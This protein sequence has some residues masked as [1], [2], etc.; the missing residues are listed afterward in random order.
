MDA[1]PCVLAAESSGAAAA[2]LAVQ[3]APRRFVGQVLVGASWQ[4]TER[5]ASDP[6][7]AALRR[8]YIGTLRTFIDNCL[9]ETDSVDLRRWALQMLTRSS[10]EDAVE[11]LRCREGIVTVSPLSRVSLPTLLIHGDLDRIAPLE[12]SRALSGQLG[13]AELQ[14]LAGLGHVPIVT[15]PAPVAALIDSFGT[16]VSIYA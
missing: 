6:F 13:C 15:A 1:G 3:R 14:V 7:V 2:L 8:D 11:L 10:V 12:G 9:P 4:R 5:G 16:H